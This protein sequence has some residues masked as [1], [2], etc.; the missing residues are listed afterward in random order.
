MGVGELGYEPRMRRL[1]TAL[2]MT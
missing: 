1:S 2:E